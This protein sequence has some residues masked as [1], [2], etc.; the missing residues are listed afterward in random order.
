[1]GRLGTF[2]LC[3]LEPER[4]PVAQDPLSECCIRQGA[5]QRVF[6]WTMPRAFWECEDGFWQKGFGVSGSRLRAFRVLGFI[7]P[8]GFDFS[9]KFLASALTAN[10][11][12]KSSEPPAPKDAAPTGPPGREDASMPKEPQPEV[13]AMPRASCGLLGEALQRR[14]GLHA[15]DVPWPRLRTR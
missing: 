11:V 8:L 7:G 10:Q 9:F 2:S 13:K 4:C 5:Q 14:P 15:G 3:A 6:P 1:M 12:F